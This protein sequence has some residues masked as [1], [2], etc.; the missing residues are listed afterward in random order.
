MT[1]WSFP[2]VGELHRWMYRPQL[3]K[4]GISLQEHLGYST[5]LLSVASLE[6]HQGAFSLVTLA[7]LIFQK[8]YSWHF[9]YNHETKEFSNLVPRP[10]PAFHHLQYEKAG[11]AWYL[12]SREHD[13]I[14]KWWKFSEQTGCVSRISQLTTRSTLG[15]YDNRPPLARYV[16]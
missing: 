7:N 9:Y 15:V 11:R 2:L 16:R 8:T 10:L 13:V 4:V 1:R 14:G 12:F 6:V 3:P 5:T